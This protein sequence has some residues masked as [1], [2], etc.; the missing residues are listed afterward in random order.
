MVFGDR[1]AVKAALD[2]RDGLIP[3]FLSN[4]DMMNEMAAVD[5]KAVWSLLDQKGDAAGDEERDG[6]S[7]S[8][9]RL[10]HGPE[11]DEEL[12]VHDGFCERRALQPWRW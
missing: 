7:G 8:A 12:A 11:P 2:A 5:S 9:G 6:R 1:D 3:N 10:R 4:S